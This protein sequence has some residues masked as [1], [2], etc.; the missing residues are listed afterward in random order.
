ME[1]QKEVSNA[2]KG[3]VS[4]KKCRYVH[5]KHRDDELTE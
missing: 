2:E 3:S 4:Q 5:H 1:Y